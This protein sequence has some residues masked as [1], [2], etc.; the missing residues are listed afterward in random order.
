MI[1]SIR[2]ALERASKAIALLFLSVVALGSVTGNR[3][4]EFTAGLA[5]LALLVQ[6]IFEVRSAVV[7]ER[8]T[9]WFER[10]EDAM[11]Y[12]LRSIDRR[13]RDGQQV[14]VR[15]IGVTQYAGWP[16]VQRL[17][18]GFENGTYHSSASLTVDLYLLDPNGLVCR[19]K[20]GP[21]PT[22]IRTTI[23]S[24]ERFVRE[25]I[26]QTVAQRCTVRVHVYDQRPTWHGV[27]VD[28]DRLYWSTC[29]PADLYL[30][31]PQGP[32]ELVLRAGGASQRHRIDHFVAWSNALS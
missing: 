13:L 8:D 9:K 18:L 22:Q 24:I 2:Q 3:A 4:I 6:V 12:V 30:T 1:A 31:A 14:R 26:G 5:L 23:D 20:H 17:L 16:P 19:D 7:P 29:L 11:P 10:F 27:L 21:D 25:R 32:A 15:W 28:D